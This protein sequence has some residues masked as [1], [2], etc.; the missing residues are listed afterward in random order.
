ML[1]RLLGEQFKVQNLG[2]SGSTL[3]KTG[4][5]G[6]LQVQRQL[7]DRKLK[8]AVGGTALLAIASSR[9]R[10]PLAG[11]WLAWAGYVYLMFGSMMQNVWK[12]RNFREGEVGMKAKL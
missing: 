12:L 4:K 9:A 5:L 3:S 6:D 2:S 10:L 7:A 8:A 11:A 1:Q